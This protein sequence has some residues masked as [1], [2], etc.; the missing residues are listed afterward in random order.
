MQHTH[1]HLYVSLNVLSAQLQ[2]DGGRCGRGGR[3]QPQGQDLLPPGLPIPWARAHVAGCVVRE[4][5]ADQQCA[6]SARPGQHDCVLFLTFFFFFHI[7]FFHAWV[8]PCL[9]PSL[10]EFSGVALSSCTLCRLTVSLP[11]VVLVKKKNG[12]KKVLE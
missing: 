2:V 5:Q 10:I 6:R 9:W 1:N 11:P 4:G 12:R 8:L 3:Q 7:I